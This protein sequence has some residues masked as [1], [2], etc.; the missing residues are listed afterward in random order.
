MVH[1]LA[2]HNLQNLA[3]SSYLAIVSSKDK[4]IQ[5]LSDP[6]KSVRQACV[7]ALSNIHGID[8]KAALALTKLCDDADPLVR[9]SARLSLATFYRNHER[10][11]WQSLLAQVV[12]DEGLE[13]PAR[14][15]AYADLWR[16]CHDTSDA[17]FQIQDVLN[18]AS[19]DDLELSW[20]R[21][22]VG[23]ATFT[24]EEG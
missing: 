9:S 21:S 23:G 5:L 8:D 11:G 2:R 24:K 3:G 17:A 18:K 4:A 12:L 15:G 16:L 14:L 22:F 6:K 13:V 19:L 10:A 20:V 1:D 7:S